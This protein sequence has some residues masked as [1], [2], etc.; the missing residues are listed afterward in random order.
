MATPL[1]G[2]PVFPLLRRSVPELLG[3]SPGR[4][5]SSWLVRPPGADRDAHSAVLPPRAWK[6]RARAHENRFRTLAKVAAAG[7]AGRWLAF[8]ARSSSSTCQPRGVVPGES[9]QRGTIPVRAFVCWLLCVAIEGDLV[10][11]TS[12]TVDGSALTG[13][14]LNCGSWRFCWAVLALRMWISYVAC[15]QILARV[16]CRVEL[17][18]VTAGADPAAARCAQRLVSIGAGD[19]CGC[20]GLAPCIDGCAWRRLGEAWDRSCRRRSSDVF[21]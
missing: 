10:L 13:R 19:S 21:S 2:E 20:D 6:R 9:K 14:V 11:A 12:S 7:Q 1:A 15:R 16:W 5:C 3:R 4:D 17:S 8:P 18:T